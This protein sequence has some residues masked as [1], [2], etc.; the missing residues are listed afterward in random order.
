MRTPEQIIERVEEIK[1]NDFFGFETLDLLSYVP[2]EHAKPYLRDDVTE[3]PPE[4]LTPRE[5]I[6]DY[7]PFA[8]EK[9]RNQRGISA[10]RSISHL[11]AWA[12]LDG[13]A[14][15][16]EIIGDGQYDDYGIS[17]LEEVAEYLGVSV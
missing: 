6:I 4:T 1:G 5:K 2:L 11:K 12:W 3:W 14:E 13:D 9:A 10:S 7:L 15:L 17:I 16:I 8:F